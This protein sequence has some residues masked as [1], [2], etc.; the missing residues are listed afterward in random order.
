LTAL[1]SGS[2]N[3]GVKSPVPPGKDREA[4]LVKAFAWRALL[5][6]EFRVSIILAAERLGCYCSRFF[7]GIDEK[8][9]AGSGEW[10]GDERCR[11]DGEKFECGWV[12][13]S[14][15]VVVDVA[16]VPCPCGVGVLLTV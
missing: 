4:G 3:G 7:V 2:E 9:S 16:R 8:Q 10:G 14:V 5:G 13:L 11:E 12:V 6:W 15:V 1:R